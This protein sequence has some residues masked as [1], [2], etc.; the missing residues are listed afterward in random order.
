MD[1][2]K[3]SSN[4]S[5]TLIFDS[6]EA[7][8]DFS[9]FLK[10]AEASGEQEV[11]LKAEN[12]ALS[13]FG[14][15]F[16]GASITR[17]EDRMLVH[18]GFK[19]SVEPASSVNSVVPIRSVLDRLARKEGEK[20]HLL[21]PD[22]SVNVSWAGVLP[23]LSGWTF[24]SPISSSSLQS[25]AKQ[26]IERVAELMPDDPGMAVVNS[27]RNSVWGLEVLPGLK[28]GGAFGL[29]VM[30]FLDRG[31]TVE[32]WENRTWQRLKADLGDVFVRPAVL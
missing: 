23:P 27:V 5:P 14:C 22:S 18:R 26:G 28:A 19:V 11:V 32:L 10:R 29:E 30:G 4:I 15:I 13:V 21:V 20:T 31:E 2:A 1:M 3:S 24:K 6:K 16:T 12:G 25:V 9:T 7:I 8:A 17:K